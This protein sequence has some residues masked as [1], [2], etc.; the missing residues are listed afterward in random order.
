MTTAKAPCLPGEPRVLFDPV[1]GLFRG[2]SVDPEHRLRGENSIRVVPPLP[3][4]PLSVRTDWIFRH[5]VVPVERDL[6][7]RWTGWGRERRGPSSSSGRI[8]PLVRSL[9]VPPSPSDCRPLRMGLG[10]PGR[11]GL[12]P[13]IRPVA[14]RTRP[15]KQ[16]PRFCPVLCLSRAVLR[17]DNEGR[18]LVGSYPSTP[19]FRAPQPSVV[20]GPHDPT[21][22]RLRD[23]RTSGGLAQERRLFLWPRP[24]RPA[25]QEVGSGRR[26]TP[27]IEA[28]SAMT[29]ARPPLFDDALPARRS[30]ACSRGGA[31]CAAS[32]PTRW[33]R[34]LRP[35]R[36]WRRPMSA[37]RWAT[38]S[39]GASCASADPDR[40][41][42]DGRRDFAR[43]NADA[44]PALRPTPGRRRYRAAEARGP[45]RGPGAP[46]GFLRR[47]RPRQGHGLGRATMPEMLR[48]SVVVTAVSWPSGSSARA[49]GLGDRLGLDPRAG[50]ASRRLLDVPPSLA[51]RLLS[52]RRLHP[53]EEHARP[54]TGPTTGGRPRIAPALAAVRSGKDWSFRRSRRP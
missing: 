2:A 49:H 42:G 15:E 38:A 39:P 16:M 26:S 7:E 17:H 44:G 22:Q 6:R 37:R 25:R 27:P 23:P 18:T 13:P 3:P 33:R 41:A 30:A 11:K 47:E 20:S 48:Y 1:E 21:S 14:D 12:R 36:A 5:G 50:G 4:R 32:G 52:L 8:S 51:A 46:C 19:E 28:G 45:A 29:D 54:R 43:C 24:G 9:I 53:M 40:R 35:L 34:T 31:T 10:P